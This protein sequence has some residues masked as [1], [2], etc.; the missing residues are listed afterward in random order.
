VPTL[1]NSFQQDGGAL[2]LDGPARFS[3]SNCSGQYNTATAGSGGWLAARQTLN[4]SLNHCD[5]QQNSATAGAGGAVACDQCQ[6]VALTG[7]QLSQNTA[8]TGGGISL[9][10]LQQQALVKDTAVNGNV[11][12]VQGSKEEE[13]VADPAQPKPPG[14]NS[15]GSGG[16]LCVELQG[17][18]AQLQNSS[19]NSNNATFG[20]TQR[21]SLP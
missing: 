20:G 7:G 13:A 15:A 3:C 4:L 10:R 19:I 6:A 17:G 5:L 14:C 2:W 8:A 18:M 16:G 9:T 1:L 12:A 11:A 21:R